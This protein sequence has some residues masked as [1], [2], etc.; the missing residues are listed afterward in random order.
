MKRR[1]TG[2]ILNVASIAGF[3]PA[4]R[5]ALYA[6][7]KAFVLSFTE[8]IA[9]ELRGSGV[10][11]TAL[12]PGFTDTPMLQASHVGRSLP[13]PLVMSAQGVAE[14]GVAACLAGQVVCVPG[15]VNLATVSG[16]QLLPRAIVRTLGGL[17]RRILAGAQ[18]DISGSLR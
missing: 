3:M 14:Q 7:S 5:I 6:A 15:L 9:E 1:G 11:A 17:S 18:R 10:S 2:R 16:A 8:G 4:P 12:C 13:S